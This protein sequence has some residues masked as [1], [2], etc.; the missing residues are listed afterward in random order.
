MT[1]PKPD[2]RGEYF[3]RAAVTGSRLSIGHVHP[4]NAAVRDYFYFSNRSRPGCDQQTLYDLLR[5]VPSAGPVDLRLALKVRR[6]ELQTDAASKDQLQAVERA[7]NLLA[8][9]DLRSCYQTLLRDPDA[10]A[11]FPYG[12]FGALLV[13]GDSRQTGRPFSPRRSYRSSRI[14]GSGDSV[15]PSGK[16]SFSMAMPFI[17]TAGEK[18]KWSWTRSR[19]LLRLTRHGTSGG[20]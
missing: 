17:V 11:L 2:K 7:F 16:S 5:T 10:P 4:S 15:L 13:A 19:F 12:G 14:V 8:R 3:V 6:L 20:T 9:P 1:Q 18:R